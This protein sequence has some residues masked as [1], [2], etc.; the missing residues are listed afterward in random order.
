MSDKLTFGPWTISPE[1]AKPE[2]R[3]TRPNYWIFAGPQS[4]ARGIG[5]EADARLMAAAPELLAFARG[6]LDALEPRFMMTGCSEHEERALKAIR[7]AI[8]KA[9]GK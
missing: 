9:E 5:S 2:A 4:I 1:H 8:A 6:M 3:G 7:A